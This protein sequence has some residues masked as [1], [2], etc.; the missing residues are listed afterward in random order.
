M[1][2]GLSL[3]LDT[4]IW[5]VYLIF[6]QTSTNTIHPLPL[7]LTLHISRRISK[8]L[9]LT[10][11]QVTFC[12]LHVVLV[13][14]L[15]LLEAEVPRTRHPFAAS[16]VG[17]LQRRRNK[18]F[19]PVRHPFLFMIPSV[20][21]CEEHNSV[22]TWSSHKEFGTSGI[23]AKKKIPSSKTEKIG[24]VSGQSARHRPWPE[25]RLTPKSTRGLGDHGF[26]HFSKRWHVFFN[27]LWNTN[28][29]FTFHK[30]ASW[31][32]S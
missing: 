28:V 3:C 11:R 18:W 8:T 17:Y 6:I 22:Y 9:P 19:H 4:L 21:M 20:K 30:K 5:L 32:F 10:L 16:W 25:R 15:H 14:A 31:S 23:R 1:V 13:L 24:Q 27:C 26:L 12:P 29:H 7:Q 2:P